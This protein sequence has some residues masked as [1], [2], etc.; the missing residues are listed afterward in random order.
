MIEKAINKN[1]INYRISLEIV[2]NSLNMLIHKGNTKLL[3]QQLSG[4]EAFALELS[5]KQVLNRFSTVGT[6]QLLI[7]DEG[8][9]V[10]DNSNLEIFGQLLKD[11]T[12]RYKHILLISHN[13]MV[14][15]LATSSITPTSI[16]H[17]T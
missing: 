2:G 1:L 7:L 8:F 13:E 3:P 16:M 14:K 10:I 6:S 9:D 4:Y 11:I 12:K 15:T 17:T 5:T